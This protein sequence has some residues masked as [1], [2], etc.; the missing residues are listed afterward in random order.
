MTAS[1]S[2]SPM[3]YADFHPILVVIATGGW[4]VGNIFSV[5]SNMVL[6]M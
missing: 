6:K 1:Q 2:S 5:Q 3:A 4:A